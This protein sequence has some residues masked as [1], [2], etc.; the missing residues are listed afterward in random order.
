MKKLYQTEVKTEI[1]IPKEV[2]K[3]EFLKLS[4]YEK[5]DDLISLE[6]LV[7]SSE[8]EDSAVIDSL[9]KFLEGFD[10][11]E[12]LNELLTRGETRNKYYLEIAIGNEETE[13]PIE[14]KISIE[15]FPKDLGI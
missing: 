8:D 2:E 6:Y 15:I 12:I 13:K 1:L 4:G 10:N 9:A 3:D 11:A 7:V 14:T 5:E